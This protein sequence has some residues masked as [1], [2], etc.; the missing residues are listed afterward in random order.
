MT[1]AKIDVLDDVH[2]WYINAMRRFHNG[3]EPNLCDVIAATRGWLPLESKETMIVHY[4]DKEY[5]IRRKK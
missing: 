4:D 5:V 2:L 3:V 1:N